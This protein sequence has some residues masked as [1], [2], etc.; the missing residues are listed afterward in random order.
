MS[1]VDWEELPAELRQAIELRTGRVVSARSVTAG[2]NASAA[3]IITTAGNGRLFLKGVRDDDVAGATALRWES[4]LNRTV[5][6]VGPTIRHTY[7]AGG[8]FCLAFIL[9]EGRHADMGPRSED[10]GAIAFT[11][12]QMQKLRAPQTPVPRFAQRFTAHLK[13]GEAEKL[14]GSHLLHTDT[15]PHN[16]MIGDHGGTAYVIDWAMPAV[17]PSWIDPAYT[18]VRLMECGQTPAD[19]LA[20]LSGFPHWRRADPRA[21]EAFVN[22]IC[23]HWTETVGERGA[24]ASNE[25]FRQLLNFSHETTTSH[26]PGMQRRHRRSFGSSG[27]SSPLRLHLS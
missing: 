23:R 14:A 1:R 17:G 9:I 26:R 21:V 24:S 18:A 15:N 27:T 8:W 3:L 6:G 16:I 5:R 20:W 12:R 13:P 11:L 7:R 19:A 2:L 4:L 10:L 25:R 22:V